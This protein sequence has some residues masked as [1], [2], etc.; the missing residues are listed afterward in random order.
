MCLGISKNFNDALYKAF[1][2]AGVILPKHKKMIISVKDEDNSGSSTLRNLEDISS[3]KFLSQ[4]NGKIEIRITFSITLISMFQLFK[5]CRNILEIDL[6]EFDSSKVE[7]VYSMFSECSKLSSI[8]CPLEST[9]NG[10]LSPFSRNN[11]IF[12]RFKANKKRWFFCGL[13]K[14]K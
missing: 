3:Y 10:M 7:Y 8:T 1:L 5:D 2:G 6:S 11:V 4:F 9:A 12:R 14:K 13:K